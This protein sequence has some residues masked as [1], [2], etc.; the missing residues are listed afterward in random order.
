M[1]CTTDSLNT[2]AIGLLAEKNE[3]LNGFV[4]S[5][6]STSLGLFPGSLIRDVIPFTTQINPFQSLDSSPAKSCSLSETSESQ[7]SPIPRVCKI[8]EEAD[9]VAALVPCGHNL[10]CMEC[11]EVIVNKPLESE[12]KCP[13]CKDT[14]AD[15][16][17]IRA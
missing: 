4:S 17:R 2:C 13:A 8:C 5:L 7:S 6:N 3:E 10:F 9:V 12:R 14:A 15:V 11:A 16:L 1:S